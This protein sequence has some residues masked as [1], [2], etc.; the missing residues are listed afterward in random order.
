MQRIVVSLCSAAIA[1]MLCA[2]PASRADAGSSA[3]RPDPHPSHKQAP[4]PLEIDHLMIHVGPGARERVALERAGFRIAPAVNEHDGQGSASLTVELSN[5]FLELAWRDTGVSVAPGLEKVAQ[6]FERMGEWRSSGWSPLGIGLRR[7]RAAPDSLPFPTRAV[8]ASWML[9]GSSLEII[10][11]ATDTA[12]PRLWVVPRSMA[13]NGVPETDSERRRLAQRDAFLHPNHALAITA[14]R[15][16]APGGG[17]TPATECAADW[18]PV[19]FLRGP[20]WLLEVTFDH[21][22]RGMTRDLRPDLPLL[23][24]F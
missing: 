23:C 22:R 11:A 6:R 20:A 3:A 7:S 10:S 21:G 5:G 2:P 16:T 9:P 1:A 4:L 12:G 15:V 18:S 17:L 19:E 24:H 13:A 14:V 8:R